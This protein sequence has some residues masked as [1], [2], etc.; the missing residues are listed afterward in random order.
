MS[1]LTYCVLFMHCVLIL[2]TAATSVFAMDLDGKGIEINL[3]LGF[4][5]LEYEENLSE[6]LLS[7]DAEVSNVILSID[8]L[9]RWQKAFIGIQ[10]AVP[11]A[12]SGSRETWLTNNLL[13]Q[14]NSLEYGL[15]RFDIFTGY[16]FSQFFN[17]LIG[18]RSTWSRQQRSNFRDQTNQLL[19][20][21]EITEKVRA[22]Y[23]L[24]GFRGDL[25]LP[26]NW[27]A[28]YG[29]EYNLPF[30]SR[31]ENTGLPGW[32]ATDMGGYSWEAYG[33]LTYVLRD[34][35]SL[36]LK[37]CIGQLHWEGGGWQTYNSSQ[38]KW[39][40]NNTDFLSSFLY[41]KLVF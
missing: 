39:P 28:S 12:T 35:I 34:N 8:G 19:Y 25:P 11:V 38:V 6:N 23:L 29:A 9:K 13:D 33:E 16:I 3:G 20:S 41:M 40:E 21:T 27:K 1:L 4:E 31:V 30:Y 15:Y 5:Y 17:P 22:H 32:E 7:S 18:V 36:G 24:F 10:G 2:T 26:G 37:V 14:S